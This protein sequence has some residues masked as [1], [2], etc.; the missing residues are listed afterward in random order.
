MNYVLHAEFAASEDEIDAIG[1]GI[2][3]ALPPGSV[4]DL[5]RYEPL[6]HPRLELT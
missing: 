1:D 3:A 5:D 6:D 4:I 2:L